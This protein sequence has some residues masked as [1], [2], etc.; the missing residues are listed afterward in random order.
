M[1]P[2]KIPHHVNNNTFFFDKQH[3][4]KTQQTFLFYYYDVLYINECHGFFFC[5][6][7]RTFNVVEH[8]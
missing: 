6:F 1:S 4:L 2:Y 7:I 3:I 8:P 5:H